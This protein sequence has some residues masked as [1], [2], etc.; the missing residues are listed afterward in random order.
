MYSRA[1]LFIF[2]NGN[3][4]EFFGW[5]GGIFHFQNGNFRWP[6]LRPATVENKH[7]TV[8]EKHIKTTKY[9]AV[10]WNWFS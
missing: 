8:V 10:T 5:R 6:C 7:R 1:K 4:R 2:S 3:F 9:N